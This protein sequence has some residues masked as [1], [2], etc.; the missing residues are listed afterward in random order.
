MNRQFPKEDVQ[1]SNKHMKRS[2]LVAIKAMK[3][4]TTTRYHF[5][6]TRMTIIE[7]TDINKCWCLNLFRL[8]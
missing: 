6:P 1:M 8:L 4:K 5:L 3:I 2:V 7:K